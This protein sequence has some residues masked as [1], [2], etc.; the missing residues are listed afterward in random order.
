VPGKAAALCLPHLWIQ[1]AR[2]G[3]IHGV[4]PLGD[5]AGQV[6]G[7]KLDDCGC[8]QPTPERARRSARVSAKARRPSEREVTV[9]TFD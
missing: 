1:G 7:D 5:L 4:E 9:F 8:K 2:L 3:G 6:L